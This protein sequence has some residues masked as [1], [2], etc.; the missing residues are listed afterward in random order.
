MSDLSSK[1]SF[2]KISR[3]PRQN[4]GISSHGL[5]LLGGIKSLAFPYP[6]V[7]HISYFLVLAFSEFLVSRR[8]SWY[9]TPPGIAYFLVSDTS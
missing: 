3:D 7:H 9:L 1:A 8:T 4:Q 5:G 2:S 6:V